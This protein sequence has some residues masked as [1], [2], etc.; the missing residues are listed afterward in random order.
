ME[1]PENEYRYLNVYI[2]YNKDSFAS[3]DEY[4]SFISLYKTHAKIHNDKVKTSVYK[5]A[6]FDLLMPCD[7]WLKFRDDSTTKLINL[8][9]NCSMYKKT[10]SGHNM[11]VSYFLY[12]RSS[13]GKKTPLRLANSA[14]IIDSGYRGNIMACVDCSKL[15]SDFNM[16]HC[17]DYQLLC[18]QRLFQLCAG[19]LSPILVTIVDDL[20]SLDIAGA[21]TERGSGG[22]GSTGEGT[23]PGVG[24]IENHQP[25][26]HRPQRQRHL[27]GQG[28]LID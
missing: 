3:N 20:D 8:N 23:G 19:D 12:P 21:A 27:N 11:P 14:G 10:S 24:G 13:T 1:Y 5:D 25:L 2:P 18:G 22:F 9:I 16:N 4:N 15:Y 6:G 7:E 26:H 17:Y 28:M